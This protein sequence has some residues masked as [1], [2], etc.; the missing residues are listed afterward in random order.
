MKNLV[1]ALTVA[2]LM[3][4][5]CAIL[6]AVEDKSLVLYFDFEDGGG[7]TVKDRSEL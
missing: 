1:V 6:Q 3:L 7:K 5:L 2:R 4:C